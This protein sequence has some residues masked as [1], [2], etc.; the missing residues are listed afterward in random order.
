MLSIII[1]AYNSNCNLKRLLPLIDNK[2][3]YEVVIVD[4]HGQ[5]LV[6]EVV[7]SSQNNIVVK[8]LDSNMGAGMAR[9]IGLALATRDYVAFFDADDIVDET[10]LS[11]LLYSILESNCDN[12]IHFFS[13][14]SHKPDG[15]KGSRNSRYSR[16]VSS[17][18]HDGSE[19]IRYRFHVPWSK[20]YKREFITKNNLF[21][22]SVSASNDVMFSL[23]AGIKARSISVSEQSYYSVQEH[24][25]GLTG[26]DSISRLHDRLSVATRYNEKLVD[27]GQSGYRVSI[28]PL[29]FRLFKID[30]GSFFIYLMSSKYS[31]CRDVI[32]SY[33]SVVKI[34]RSL[35]YR[36]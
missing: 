14:N 33:I 12:D 7:E 32:P 35:F 10:V 25:S 16:L 1:P 21:F 13:P 9:N 19:A 20:I 28:V 6:E 23:K 4:D 2:E 31:L 15:S 34:C 29:F 8:R 24:N 30:V 18:I 36:D 26:N 5:E 3:L 27:I 17:Y 11:S 22:D